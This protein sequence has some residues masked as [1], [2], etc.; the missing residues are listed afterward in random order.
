MKKTTLLVSALCLGFA[1]VSEVHA[2]EKIF[3]CEYTSYSRSG[4]VPQKAFYRID[5]ATGA[6]YAIDPYIHKLHD[7]WIPVNAKLVKAGKYRLKYQLI[8]LKSSNAGSSKLNY[9]VNLDMNRMQATYRALLSGADNNI[10]AKA[11]C[12]PYTD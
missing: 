11:A 10:S 12:K 2:G 3:E 5:E 7:G 9:T 1:G 6:A 4:W 8:G